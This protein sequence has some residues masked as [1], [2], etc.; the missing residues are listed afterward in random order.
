MKNV[1]ELL[2][3]RYRPV[4]NTGTSRELFFAL[5]D[6][7]N[8]IKKTPEA[9]KIIG[10]IIKEKKEL[11]KEWNKYENKALEELRIAEEKVLGIIKQK[12][13]SNQALDEAIK[14]LNDWREAIG[15]AKSGRIETFLWNICKI[16]FQN[17]YKKFL[18]EF[19]EKKT[20]RPNIYL[21]NQN[22]VFSKAIEKRRMLEDRIDAL[23]DTELWGCW[24]YL[25]VAP[26]IFLKDEEFIRIIV[27]NESGAGN[28]Y[29]EFKDMFRM[30]RHINNKAYNAYFPL[31]SVAEANE[32]IQKYKSYASR[33]HIQLITELSQRETDKATGT[34]GKI[35]IDLQRG[36]YNSAYPKRIYEISGKRLQALEFLIKNKSALLKEL[37]NNNEQLSDLMVKEIKEIN[38]N[39][40]RICKIKVDLIMHSK[41]GGGYRLNKNQ[42]D[43]DIKTST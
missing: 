33:I 23:R 12:K 18:G 36:I 35:V 31:P 34:K 17:G 1:I 19:I 38:N 4:E 15:G 41:T 2:E 29:K 20:I 39:V 6:Y 43:I 8:Y 42:L 25:N 16:L 3:I 22:F 26:A 40:K 10:E 14:E 9:K 30:R 28:A 24:H 5:A 7:V 21:D 32:I 13:I 27:K 37:A 11:L